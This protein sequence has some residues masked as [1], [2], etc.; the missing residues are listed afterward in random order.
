[1]TMTRS[2]FAALAA[3]G[4]I[5]LAAC[6]PPPPEVIDHGVVF[7]VTSDIGEPVAGVR[8]FRPG[9][10]IGKTGKDGRLPTHFRAP[11]GTLLTVHAQCPDGFVDPV[12]DTTIVLR[13]LSS[14]ATGSG[15]RVSIQ[16]RRTR[17]L[18][19]I[20]VR[21]GY[22]DLPVLFNGEEITRTGTTGVAHVSAAV[23]PH[24]TFS[25]TI[26]TSSAQR[27]RPKNP[28]STFTMSA[29]DSVFVFDSGLE[30]M[31]EPRKPKPRRRPK[32][33][34]QAPLRP[35]LIPPNAHLGERSR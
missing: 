21:A 34:P 5:A 20:V 29:E 19:A 28:A 16:C 3:F 22:P 18:A 4:A 32:P 33:K 26:D 23:P 7:T 6:E 15:R 25:L 30:R 14:V 11:D 24:E 10:E 1:M 31:P 9:V 27:L 17:V 35:I 13:E 2:M 8:L 12:E